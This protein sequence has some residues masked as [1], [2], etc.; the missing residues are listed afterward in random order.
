MRPEITVGHSA[1]AAIAG[2]DVPR[3]SHGAAPVGR[4][5]W[6]TSCRSAAF[7]SHLFS[8][9]ARSA[10]AEFIGTARVRLAGISCRRGRA[11]DCQYR[12]DDRSRGALHSIVKLVG[13]SCACCGRTAR[14]MA[15]W[16][17]E[18]LLHDLR[19]ADDSAGP[20]G[21]PPIDRSISPGVA[22]RG[23]RDSS[24]AVIERLPA[25]RSSRARRAAATDHGSHR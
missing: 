18:P 8:P 25:P 4:L 10:G 1:G 6:R 23:S 13:Q 20:G 5:E 19:A 7:A 17:L 11:V 2:A 16:K 14:M 12:F 9:L 24:S 3:P 22:R 21:P 15:N